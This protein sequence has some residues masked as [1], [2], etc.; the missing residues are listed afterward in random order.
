MTACKDKPRKH[1]N[2]YAHMWISPGL[3]CLIFYLLATAM[4]LSSAQKFVYYAQY[5]AHEKT[6]ASFCTKLWVHYYIAKD[7]MKIVLNYASIMLDAFRDLLCSK[8]CWHNRPG[9]TCRS[10]ILPKRACNQAVSLSVHAYNPGLK[11]GHTC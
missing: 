9:P 6:C 8:L 11:V 1:E 10:I 2:R 4:L 7:F 5:Y 3:L